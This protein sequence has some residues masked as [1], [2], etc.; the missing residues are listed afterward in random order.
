MLTFADIW[1]INIITVVPYFHV[2]QLSTFR[3]E[4]STCSDGILQKSISEIQTVATTRY[5]DTLIKNGTS[6]L[7]VHPCPSKDTLGKEKMKKTN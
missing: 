3:L 5:G 7:S 6:K 1:S 2:F 4:A